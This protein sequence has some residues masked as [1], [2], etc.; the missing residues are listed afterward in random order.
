[1][2]NIILSAVF[3]LLSTTVA[4]Q[5]IGP[6]VRDAKDLLRGRAWDNNMGSNNYWVPPCGADGSTVWDETSGLE[7][8]AV[9]PAYMQVNKSTTPWEW[10]VIGYDDLLTDFITAQSDI[11]TLLALMAGL[12]TDIDDL[13]TAFAA[14]NS[15]MSDMALAIVDKQDSATAATDSELSSGLSGKF[16][17]PA[18]TT[19][20]YIRGDGSLQTFPSIPAAQVNSDW[21]AVSGAAQILNKPTLT[22]GTVTSVTAGTG[23][24]GGAITTTGT[25]SLPDVGTPGTYSQ[26]TTDAQG[27]VTAGT[28]R[29]FSYATRALNT[30]FQPSAT[31]DVLGT[32]SVDIATVST[33]ASGQVGTVYLRI[34][35][36][37]TCSSGTQEVTRFVNGN[38]QSLGLTVTMNQN[39]TGTLT[40][41]IPAGFWAQIVTE[42]TTG[43]PTFTA[44]PG[45]ETT[46]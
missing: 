19:A 20:Q 22:S 23:L 12:E 38:T 44:R 31:R 7:H 9:F 40:G 30:C 21:D 16:N 2:K 41:V 4:A 18:G 1:M 45:Q 15:D 5:Q 14:M 46:L 11:T 33:L 8:C 6:F 10:Q 43:T 17:T 24:S 3:L 13:E 39:I 36:N 27:R 37:N 32:Y 35:T 42:N 25:I 28:A 34:Y 29:S 26:V